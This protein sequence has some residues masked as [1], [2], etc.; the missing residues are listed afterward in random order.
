MA[1]LTPIDIRHR[2]FLKTFKG[3]SKDEVDSFIDQI[4]SAFEETI[5]EREIIA[6]R[7]NELVASLNRYEQIEKTM[8]DM[9]IHAQTTSESTK[10]QAERDAA[11]IVREAE[12]RAESIKKE[13]ENELEE[14]RRSILVLRDQK[15]TF[16]I[17]FRTL[18][19]SQIEML[20]LLETGETSALKRLK[21]EE[22]FKQ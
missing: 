17:K 18:I 12:L 1:Q 20:Q 10:Q 3:Y 13:A 19:K 15:K 14:L 7:N 2:T 11:I 16:L 22:P 9:L 21:P 5:K 4:A 6:A 8:Q